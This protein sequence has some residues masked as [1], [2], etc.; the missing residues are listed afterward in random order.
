MPT[1]TTT[2]GI[3]NSYSAQ[4]G[5]NPVLTIYGLTTAAGTISSGNVGIGT[6]TPAAFLDIAGTLGSQADLFNISSTTATDVAS[7]LFRVRANGN[8]GIGSTTPWGILSINPNGIAGP[9]FVIGSSTQCVTGDTRLR[10]RRR[11][12]D[13]SYEY[14]EPEIIDIKEGDEI[15]SLDEKTGELVWS[16]VKQLAYMG[17]KPIFKLTTTSGKTIRTTGNHPYLAR[18]TKNPNLSAGAALVKSI[19]LIDYANIKAWA[20]R[21][22]VAVDLEAL[23]T[24]LSFCGITR[25]SIYYGVDAENKNIAKFMHKLRSFG[26]DVVSKPIQYF[27]ITLTELLQQYVNARWVNALQPDAHRELVSEASRLDAEHHS[28]LVPKANFDVEITM[29]SMRAVS[30]FDHLIL[31]SG[32]GDFA[33]LI[34]HLKVSGKKTTVV[35]GREFLA[36]SLHAAAHIVAKLEDMVKL[37]PG[38]VYPLGPD[39]SYKKPTPAHEERVWE[40]CA[41]TIADLLGLSSVS[42]ATV[43]NVAAGEGS[44]FKVTDLKEGMEIAAA[45]EDGRGVWEKIVSVEPVAEEDVYDVEIEGTHNFVGNDIIAHNTAFIVTNGGSVGIGTTT[46]TS[47][48]GGV[49]ASAGPIYIGGSSATATST[50]EGN[51]R[52]LGT[53]QVG[54]GTLYLTGSSVA[55]TD[56]SINLSSGTAASTFSNNL[57]IG[58]TSPWAKLSVAGLASENGPLFTVSSST[59]TATTTAFIITSQGNVGIGTTSPAAGFAVHGTSYISGTSFF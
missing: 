2:A 37:V 57:G 14:D 34:S 51:V 35:S 25:A 17:N 22:G 47:L 58:T 36:G 8:V 28:F 39:G 53:L 1:A 56:G 52:V 16:R 26:Y 21:R 59:P 48:Y 42:R 9:A 31:F 24:V 18:T 20:R 55:S 33:P 41:S 45:A 32:D 10:R 5:G 27:K 7:S 40:N 38:L 19:V 44:W 50:F 29:D 12:A 13:G 54:S 49:F 46:P 43:D 6:T 15:Q 3:I 30:E 11:R 23:K 4:M